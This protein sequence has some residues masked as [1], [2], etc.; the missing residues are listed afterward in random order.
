MSATPI[1]ELLSHWRRSRGRSQLDLA[2]EADVSPRHLSFIETGRSQPSREMVLLLA[3]TLGLPLREQN[4]LLLAAGFAPIFREA[5]LDDPELELAKRAI[6]FV[7]EQQAPYPAVVL[8]RQWNIVRASPPAEAFFARLLEPS[9][10]APPPNVLRL[11]FDPRGLRPFVE[12]WEA[13]ASALV[14]RVHRE[15]IGGVAGD[16]T[17]R[18]LAECLAQPD[19]PKRWSAMDPNAQPAPLIA[20]HFRKGDLAMRYFS[21]VTTLGTAQDITLQELRIE[22][23]F[24]ADDETRTRAHELFTASRR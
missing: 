1:G 9:D 22:S 17:K 6:D 16:A 5:H 2:I 21:L 24:P 19:V 12:N 3:A 7:F 4:T 10:D 8:D 11:M 20:I 15:A 14:Q 13:V 18:V 23:F